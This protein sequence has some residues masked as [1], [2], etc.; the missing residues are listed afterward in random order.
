MHW[1][2]TRQEQLVLSASWDK[3]IKLVRALRNKNTCRC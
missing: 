2:Q 1:S 3:S